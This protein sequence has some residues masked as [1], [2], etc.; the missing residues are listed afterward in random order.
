MRVELERSLADNAR[1]A[2]HNNIKQKIHY[3]EQLKEQLRKLTDVS[4]K[5]DVGKGPMMFVVESK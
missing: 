2:G 5:C 1:I 4:R 3:V